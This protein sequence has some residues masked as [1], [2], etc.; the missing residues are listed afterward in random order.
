MG[1]GVE[2]ESDRAHC[3]HPR[4]YRR[5]ERGMQRLHPDHEGT[6]MSCK[7]S[8]HYTTHAGAR[9]DVVVF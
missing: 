9:G 1:Q 6:S 7:G 4:M 3:R 8:R 5:N 2:V